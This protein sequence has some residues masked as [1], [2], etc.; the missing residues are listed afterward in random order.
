VVRVVQL[1]R[2]DA[3]LDVADRIALTVAAPEDV[4]TAVRTHQDF[5]AHETLATSV[6]LVDS[7]DG[8]SLE[9]GFA[10]IVGEAVPIT[11]GVAAGGVEV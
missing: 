9:R 7:L 8:D 1:A 6:T 2:R 3:S 5:V 4:L 10:G 11:V